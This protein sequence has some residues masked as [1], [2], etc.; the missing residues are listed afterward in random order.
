[1]GQPHVDAL[2]S[3]GESVEPNSDGPAR[4]ELGRAGPRVDDDERPGA[5]RVLRGELPVDEDLEDR[6]RSDLGSDLHEREIDVELQARRVGRHLESGSGRHHLQQRE[7][8]V[9]V[10][11]ARPRR[12]P[13]QDDPAR[14][15]LELD[16]PGRAHGAADHVDGCELRHATILSDPDERAPGPPTRELR[17]ALPQPRQHVPGDL[18]DLRVSPGQPVRPVGRP[19]RHHRRARLVRVRTQHR[20]AVADAFH[21]L[22]LTRPEHT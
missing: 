11:G 12:H 20:V 1:M 5:R 14:R 6:G 8:D 10:L 3:R 13:V 17:V 18:F 22:G 9:V 4:L 7:R 19:R 21:R 16:D 2:L 15:G